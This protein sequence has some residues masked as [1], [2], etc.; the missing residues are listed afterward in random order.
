MRGSVRSDRNA[1]DRALDRLVSGR[2]SEGAGRIEPL[3]ETAALARRWLLAEVRPDTANRHLASIRAATADRTAVAVAVRAEARPRRRGLAIA[4]AATML[5]ALSA[6]Q[7]AF[8]SADA[9]PGDALYGIKRAVE[10]LNLAVH[11]DPASDAGL[12]TEFAARRLAEI[13]ALIASGR[14][15]LIGDTLQAFGSSLDSALASVE[16]AGGPDDLR[17]H[18]LGRLQIH[19]DRL[20]ELESLVPEQARDAIAN[21]IL[22]SS[23]AVANAGGEAEVGVPKGRPDEPGTSAGKGKGKG[24]ATGKARGRS[25]S[26]GGGQGGGS[27]GGG[28]Q[29]GGPPENPGPPDEPGNAPAQAN[30]G[31]QQGRKK[32]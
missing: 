5:T 25:G 16:E 14:P 8:A 6:S 26:Q 22:R 12:H 11:L 24:K 7:V 19:L 27:S 3:V 21:A 28:G 20:R 32:S 4:L 9:V 13:E 29:G 10:R 23:R 15:H 31:Q 17:A 18:V 1:L 2:P 30:Q